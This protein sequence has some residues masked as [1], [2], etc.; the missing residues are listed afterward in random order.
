MTR[1]LYPDCSIKLGLALMV[2]AGGQT[3]RGWGVRR[4]ERKRKRSDGEGRE[5][6]RETDEMREREPEG[7]RQMYRKRDRG[8]E[9][10]KEEAE[11]G[12]EDR[13]GKM[14]ESMRPGMGRQWTKS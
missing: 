11:R 7:R 10:G 13:G 14:S 4:E 6:E 12:K 5:R 9:R 2:G 1:H 3:K 8:S